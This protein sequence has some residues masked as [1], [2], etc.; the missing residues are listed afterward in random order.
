[1]FLKLFGT[2][3]VFVIFT[4]SAWTQNNVRGSKSIRYYEELVGSLS[5]QVRQLQDDNARLTRAVQEL[6]S[7]MDAL[8]RANELT[9]KELSELRKKLAADTVKREKQLQMIADRLK[10]P[11]AAQ[12]NQPPHQTVQQTP[13]KNADP[14]EK[15]SFTEYEEYVVQRGATLTAIS[16]AYGVSVDTIKKANNKTN[17][18]LRIGEKL[19]IPRK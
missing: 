5:G 14:Q 10:T 18:N 3:A 1:M 12:E 9:G 16:K 11:P 6:R 8:A 19:K 17:D 15:P 7:Q 2:A 4:T 13:K